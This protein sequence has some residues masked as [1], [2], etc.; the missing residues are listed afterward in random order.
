MWFRSAETCKVE[1]SLTEHTGR[2]VFLSPYKKPEAKDDFRAPL[3]RSDVKVLYEFQLLA[4]LGEFEAE[5][6]RMH[7]L[8]TR[9]TG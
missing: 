9:N 2:V 5:K 3:K 8:R 7:D 6:V 4:V 1:L